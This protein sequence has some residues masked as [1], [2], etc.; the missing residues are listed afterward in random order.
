MAE[1]TVRLSSQE[2]IALEDKYGCRNYEPV[3][4]VL[5]RGEGE[6]LK[7]LSIYLWIVIFI[8]NS[9]NI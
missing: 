7:N 5:S 3:P 4:V 9:L 6:C 8:Y 1:N 2:I